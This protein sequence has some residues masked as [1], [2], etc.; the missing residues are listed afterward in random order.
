MKLTYLDVLLQMSEEGR[1][2]L[3]WIGKKIYAGLYW[4]FDTILRTIVMSI[5]FITLCIICMVIVWSSTGCVPATYMAYKNG[6]ET[7]V[8]SPANETER[9]LINMN[10]LGCQIALYEEELAAYK[11]RRTVGCIP[12]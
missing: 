1:S 9:L 8:E 5:G 4:T 6:K 10:K 12:K 7:V 3:I 2:F 11:E